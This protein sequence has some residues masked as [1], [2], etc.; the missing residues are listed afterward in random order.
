MLSRLARQFRHHLEINP[1]GPAWLLDIAASC[2]V[3]SLQCR[4]LQ[5]QNAGIRVRPC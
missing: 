2:I 5:W 3:L 1:I 4:R